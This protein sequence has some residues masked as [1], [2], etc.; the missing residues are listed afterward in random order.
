ASG[1]ASVVRDVE[2]ASRMWSPSYSAWF[3]GGPGDPDLSLIKVELTRTSTSEFSGPPPGAK[4]PPGMKLP[5][6]PPSTWKSTEWWVKGIGMVKTVTT[7]Q[8]GTT[9]VVAKS[10]TGL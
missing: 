4:L 10:V 1:Q 8:D 2:A 3:A 9:T 5:A 6:M 7:G